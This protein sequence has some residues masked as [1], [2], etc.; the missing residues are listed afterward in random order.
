MTNRSRAGGCAGTNYSFLTSYER[1]TETQ[2]DYAKARYFSSVQGRFISSDP[3]LASGRPAVP[4]SW[5]RYTYVLNNPL[6]LVDPDGLDWGATEWIDAEGRRHTNYHYFAGKVG[7]YKGRK[8]KAVDFGKSGFKDINADDGTI[9]RISNVGTLR[10]VVYAGPAGGG[11]GA[12]LQVLNTTAGFVDGA[13]PYGRQIREAAFGKMGVDTSAPEYEN[14]AAISEGVSVGTTLLAGG[15]VRIAGC[16]VETTVPTRIY[17][18]RV[19]IRSAKEPSPYHN[20]PE[21]FNDE[22][23]RGSRTVTIN[24]FKSR[25]VPARTHQ[26]RER[27]LL[28][29]AE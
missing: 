3:L 27:R 25:T 18:A 23:F 6:V 9:V 22:I 1:D 7:E 14:A 11:S 8:Y 16:L 20:F 21:S 28:T 13:I 19:L 10:Q 2:L 12:G 29:F 15:Q 26:G 4:E 24:F 5:N 17:S